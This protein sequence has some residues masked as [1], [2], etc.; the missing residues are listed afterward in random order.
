M[1]IP[2]DYLPTK[3]DTIINN[4]MN[5][6]NIID[7]KYNTDDSDQ[8]QMNTYLIDELHMNMVPNKYDYKKIQY[9]IYQ[10]IFGYYY[11]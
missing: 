6:D 9:I 7:I 5:I 11:L 4:N 1:Y 10:Y 8:V 3:L 2:Y